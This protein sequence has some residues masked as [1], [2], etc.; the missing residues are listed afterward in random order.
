MNKSRLVTM[1]MA[2]LVCALFG[3][4][5]ARGAN[6]SPSQPGTHLSQSPSTP[7]IVVFLMDD[8]NPHDGRLWSDPDRTPA[9]Y[10]NFIEQGVNFPNAI[11][12]SPLC[13]PGRASILTGLHTHNNGVYRNDIRLLH[14]DD[15]IGVELQAV[16]YE[17]MWVGKYLNQ[18][19]KL[20]DEEWA[21][22]NTGWTHLEAPFTFSDRVRT[23]DG[24]VT[25]P[26]QHSTQ[27]VR[28]RTV[29]LIRQTPA[30]VPLFAVVAPYNLHSPN[31]PMPVPQEELDK[32]AGFPLWNPP[33]YNEADVSDKP[34]YV[35]RLPLRNKLDG[36]SM[37][38]YCQEMF[39]IESVVKNVVDELD[40]Q[41]RL[42]NTLLV[43]T[44]DNGM[45]WG[46]HRF[47]QSKSTPY[48]TPVP[49][50]FSWPSRWGSSP[51]TI[52][53]HTTNIDLGPTFCELAGC[54]LGPYASGQQAADGVSLL[55]L[56]DG[57]N[58]SLG[59]TAIL[60]TLG[61]KNATAPAWWAVRTT[62]ESQLGLWHY[63]EY[64]TGEKEL[65]NLDPGADP[66]ELENLAGN[67]NYAQV[68][69][70]LAETLQELL[71]EGRIN[72]PDAS[73]A[74]PG[75]TIFRGY[76]VFADTSTPGQTVEWAG[77]IRG[78]TYSFTV[79][80]EN[81]TLSTES[82]AIHSLES[83]SLKFRVRYLVNGRDV[84]DQ[85]I[86]SGYVLTDVPRGA[87]NTMTVTI[88]A[89]SRAKLGASRR[90]AV[91]VSSVT[92]PDRKDVVELI[93]RR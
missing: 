27:I 10:H 46:A 74:P 32:C 75:S 65:Y 48:A 58:S 18:F 28:D 82:F 88:R 20:T 81:N 11:G 17:T 1:A 7:N 45:A 47:G 59:R 80:V 92:Y 73:A 36:W 40:A 39:G 79:R 66:Y 67:S 38:K 2:M 63:V 93:G 89:T 3:A 19:Q 29:E 68:Q 85:V 42:D 37:V 53:Q 51:R 21:R 8:V 13:C 55:G 5:P 50:Y 91:T 31:T 43:F 69:A 23:R 77:L 78:K 76:N 26:G 15:Q 16:G 61:A 64:E 87:F 72:R 49:L 9:I 70:T 6:D 54:A 4:T 52:S 84:T 25:Y 12:E 44:A 22:Y 24:W 60:E 83:G 56:L 86:G 41:G 33:N 62:T 90:V 14:P 35:R 71:A 34:A 30:E 57:T